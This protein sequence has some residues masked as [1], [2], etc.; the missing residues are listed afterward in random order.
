MPLTSSASRTWS[1]SS[2]RWSRRADRLTDIERGGVARA[3]GLQG[4]GLAAGLDE[5]LAPEGDD[6]AGVLGQRDDLGG[7]HHPADRVLPAHERFDAGH[8][9]RPHVDDRLVAE[10]ELAGV[11]RPRQVGLELEPGQ[12]DA[13]ISG[14]N[15]W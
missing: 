5:Q 15:T 12:R 10:G 8:L 9:A 3:G 1:M 13:C 11:E 4:G 2:G 7:R 14:S 6:E